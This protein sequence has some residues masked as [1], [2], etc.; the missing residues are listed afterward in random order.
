[1][2]EEPDCQVG[3]WRN[4]RVAAY[5]RFLVLPPV[6]RTNLE[7]V[8]RVVLTPSLRHSGMAARW[9]IAE[10]RCAVPDCAPRPAN[11]TN[12]PWTWAL[13]DL[14]STVEPAP[15]T[16][17]APPSEMTGFSVRKEA[18]VSLEDAALRA[19]VPKDARVR[20]EQLEISLRPRWPSVRIPSAPPRSRRELE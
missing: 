19:R 4:R 6:R 9:T 11:R 14:L 5:G 7:G 17:G 15:S 20:G 13:R 16:W 1:M 2:P 18:L 10:P 3:S 8:L 12:A